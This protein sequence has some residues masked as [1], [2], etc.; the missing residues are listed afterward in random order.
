MGTK[1]TGNQ[2]GFKN[3]LADLDPGFAISWFFS[4]PFSPITQELSPQPLDALLASSMLTIGHLPYSSANCEVHLIF[5]YLFIFL[6]KQTLQED[7]GPL[8]SRYLN[9]SPTQYVAVD[10]SLNIFGLFSHLEK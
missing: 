5:I 6:V 7:F 8:K 1:G 10:E 4:L 3:S 9:D 2:C